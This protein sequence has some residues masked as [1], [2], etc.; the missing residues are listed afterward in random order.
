MLDCDGDGLISK[1]DLRK[2]L[3]TQYRLAGPLIT[4]SG[5]RYDDVDSLT[6]DFFNRIDIRGDG[7]ITMEAYKEGA[8]KN[9]D[10]VEG[11]KLFS[12]S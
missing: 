7:Q 1:E 3:D 8:L 9:L 2:V 6:D 12:E 4:F 11:F 10:I 5:K